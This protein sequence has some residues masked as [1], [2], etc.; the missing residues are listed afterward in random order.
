VAK[1]ENAAPSEASSSLS[2]MLKHPV[3]VTRLLNAA[4]S[5]TNA[6]LP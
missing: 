6:V 4:S 1:L 2:K 5:V 3:T